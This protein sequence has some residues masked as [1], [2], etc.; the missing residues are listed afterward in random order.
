M[1]CLVSRWQGQ[2]GTKTCHPMLAM[3]GLNYFK[4]EKENGPFMDDWRE[5]DLVVRNG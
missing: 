5:A 3:Q 2:I 4:W 1:G